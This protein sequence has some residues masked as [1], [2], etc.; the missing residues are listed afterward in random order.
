MLID[1]LKDPRFDTVFS[2][3]MGLF[4]M[5][6]ARPSCKGEQCF[7]FKAPPMKEVREHAYKINDRCYKFVAKDVKCPSTGVIEPFQWEIAA[8][9]K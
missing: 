2:L 4:I 8:S 1:I 7:K 5:I 3:L 6:L 9:G